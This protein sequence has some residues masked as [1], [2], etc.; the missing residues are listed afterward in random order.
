[1]SCLIV[2]H[3]KVKKNHQLKYSFLNDLKIMITFVTTRK[4]KYGKTK[5]SLFLQQLW[6]RIT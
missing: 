3:A 5:I 2:R 1:M 4:T 6:Q